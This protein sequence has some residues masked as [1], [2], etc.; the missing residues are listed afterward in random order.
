MRISSLLAA[1]AVAVSAGLFAA[2]DPET[3]FRHPPFDAKPGVW[4][5][6]MGC[7]VTKDGIT[8]DLEAFR[9]AGIG[10]ATVF[11][12]A[13]VC[14]PWAAS[15]PNSPTQGLVAFTDPWWELLRFAAAEARRTGVGIGLH[16]CPG[17]TSTGGPWIPPEFAMRQIFSSCTPVEGGKPF[18]ARLSL[19]R[20]DPRGDMLFPMVNEDKGVL[21]KPEI[22]ARTN[23]WRDIAVLAL[24][25]DGIVPKDAILDLSDRLQ[26]DGSFEWTPPAG[27]WKV[28]RFAHTAMGAVTQPNQWEARGLECDKMNAAAVEFHL[29][30]VVGE[31]K[32]HLGDLVGTG[33]THVLL[34]SYEAGTPSWTPAMAAEF[35]TRR[36]YSLREFLPV[37]AARRVVGSEDETA[38][39]RNDFR[40]TIAD[41]YRDNLFK[42]MARVLGEAGLRFD[43]EP[44]GGPF[45]TGEVSPY[46]ERAMTE[47]WSEIKFGFRPQDG[48]FNGPG[49][50]RRNI[51]S[52][53]AFTGLP[54]NSMWTE[55]PA[56]L[57]TAGDSAFLGGVNKLVLHTNPLQPWAEGVRP[58][59]TMGQWGTHFGRTQTWW[60]PGKA[61]F[62]YLSRC[63]A[64][65][66]WGESNAQEIKVVKAAPGCTPRAIGRKSGDV[67][68]W[69]VAVPR[70]SFGLADVVFPV[71]DLQPEL[72]NPVT[73]EIR[74]IAGF[75]PLAHGVRVPLAFADGQSFFIV[76][77]RPCVEPS[78]QSA[79]VDFLVQEEVLRIEN[80][81]TVAFDPSL[82][83]PA[84]PVEFKNLTDWTSNAVAGIRY[85]SGTAVYRTTFTVP[86]PDIIV[87]T[88]VQG[89]QF[90]N[91]LDLGAV[92]GLARVRLNGRNLGIVWCAPSRMTIPDG[93]LAKGENTL[94]IEVTNTWANRF[95]GD[96]QEP[97]DCEWKV[98]HLGN[99]GRYLAKFPDWFVR[100]EKRPTKRIAFATW[101]Y[102][103]KDSPLVPSGLIGPVRFVK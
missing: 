12:M 58:G 74:D 63:Q 27:P 20:I 70:G 59:M 101:N 91:E 79:R 66:Q 60:K 90:A 37:L 18:R 54:Q 56:S 38:R 13:D 3:V 2:D 4:W 26:A 23:D 32:K 9:D 5:H 55:T 31:M 28:Y 76:F 22:P 75:A 53:E 33:L 21:E 1:V 102:F 43:C 84:E 14:T 77:R 36:G 97:D 45:A 80:P 73:G 83:G 11:G 52:A 8:R 67:S 68:L 49:G 34:D 51:L 82:G 94:E 61:W 87:A 71:K 19:P 40:R 78:G 64:L 86:A 62:D 72:W 41:L 65:L 16:N 57:K 88:T 25:A 99:T 95:I 81:W 69:F 6:W 50:K 96:E 103:T 98:G 42:T 10:E 47:F 35:Q 93:V 7:N 44:Y 89:R 30:R 100:C 29:N 48:I 15:I 85:Y 46:V 17:Y 92:R 24:P 39:F